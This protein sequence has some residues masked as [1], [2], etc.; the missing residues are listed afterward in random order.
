MKKLMILLACSLPLIG[1]AQSSKKTRKDSTVVIIFNNNS[2]SEEKK[3]S[4]GEDNIIKIAP[5]GFINGTFPVYFER[6]INDFFTIQAG[7]GLTGRNYMRS[8]IRQAANIDFGST[9]SEYKEMDYPWLPTSG[10]YDEADRTFDFTHRKAG[11]GFMASIQP[12]FY[13]ESDAP[14]G[15]FMGL[16]LDY[17]RY[18]FS[19][20]GMVYNANIFS[21]EHK[22]DTKKEYENLTDFMVYWGY[23]SVFDKLTV[24]YTTGLGYRSVKGSKYAFSSGVT[25]PSE[26]F[27][28]YKQGNFNFNIGVKVGYHF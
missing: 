17:G 1:M 25:P 26:G 19:I 2:D 16:S 22:G 13:F 10:L 8:W 3:K 27:A 5:L 7:V 12:R 21:W 4:T 23:Q 14:D 28:T 24:E 18:N 11:I 20:P 15:A 6:R 9:E